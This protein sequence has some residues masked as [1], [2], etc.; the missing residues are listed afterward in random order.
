MQFGIIDLQTLLSFDHV[1]NILSYC[2][3]VLTIRQ[4]GSYFSSI[5]KT[6]IVERMV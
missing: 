5:A 4:M 6:K 3:R 2:R 1:T